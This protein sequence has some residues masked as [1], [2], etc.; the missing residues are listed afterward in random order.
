MAIEI[1]NFPIKNGDVPQLCKKL[2]EAIQRGKRSS[3]PVE[4]EIQKKKIPAKKITKH[5]ESP[6]WE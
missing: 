2:P 3:F 5:T 1:V 6:V 4:T